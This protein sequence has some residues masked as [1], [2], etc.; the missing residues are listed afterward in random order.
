VCWKGKEQRT[1]LRSQP[2]KEN[3][4]SKNTQ[5]SCKVVWKKKREEARRTA[6]LKEK[7]IRKRDNLRAGENRKPRPSQKKKE[8]NPTRKNGGGGKGKSTRQKGSK[9]NIRYWRG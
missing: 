5:A 3:T 4:K 7:Q 9:V 1:K 8:R 2:R 6:L